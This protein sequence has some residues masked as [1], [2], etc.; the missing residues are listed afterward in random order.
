MSAQREQSAEIAPVDTVSVL[1]RWY[2]DEEQWMFEGT[3]IADSEHDPA[4]GSFV[5]VA[6]RDAWDRRQAAWAELAATY[7]LLV[8]AGQ[9]LDDTPAL[10]MRCD[11]FAGEEPVAPPSHPELLD[12]RRAW[13]RCDVCGRHRESHPMEKPDD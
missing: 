13:Q 1:A 11:V 3:E 9:L 7:V 5:F 4:H 8:E 6:P 10:D 2:E 12:R